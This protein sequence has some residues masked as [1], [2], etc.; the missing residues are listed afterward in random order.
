MSKRASYA[1]GVWPVPNQS[2]DEPANGNAS[3]FFSIQLAYAATPPDQLRFG[4]F[5]GD[6]VTDVFALVQSC[7]T[8]LPAV[9]RNFQ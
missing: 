6:G 1:P 9:E 8:Y 3:D 4:D 2:Q 5:N 7:K